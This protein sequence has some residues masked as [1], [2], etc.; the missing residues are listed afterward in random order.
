MPSIH[1]GK[2]VISGA[3]SGIEQRTALALGKCDT[4]LF[5]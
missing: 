5:L 2:V 1:H 4:H 3:S